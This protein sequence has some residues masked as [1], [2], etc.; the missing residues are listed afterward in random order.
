MFVYPSLYEGFGIPLL[1]A[2]QMNCPI[3]CSSTSSLP[4]VCSDAAL[5]F[6]PTDPNDVQQQIDTLAFDANL[7][8]AIALKGVERVTE[9][10]WQRCATETKGI[11]EQVWD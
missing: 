11:Y 10:S 7:A 6:D 5:Y 9:F 3:A 4:E 1:E 2:M 8:A